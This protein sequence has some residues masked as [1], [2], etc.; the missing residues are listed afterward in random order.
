MTEQEFADLAEGDAV[1][2]HSGIG[3][4]RYFTAQ[5]AGVTFAT[6]DTLNF[7]YP[8]MTRITKLYELTRDQLAALISNPAISV[9]VR[10]DANL[11]FDAKTDAAEYR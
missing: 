10:N 11:E 8:A 1:R 2:T 7:E 9:D 5:G 6:D 4:I 3:C